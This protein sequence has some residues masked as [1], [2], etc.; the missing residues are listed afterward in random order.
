MSQHRANYARDVSGRTMPARRAV[1]TNITEES[2]PRCE[3]HHRDGGRTMS[4]MHRR[5]SH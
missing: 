3:T 4:A 5:A 1:A 2:C